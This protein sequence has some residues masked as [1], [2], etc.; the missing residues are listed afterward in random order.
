M[1]SAKMLVALFTL[2]EKRP[3]SG[4]ATCLSCAGPLHNGL[5]YR[6]FDWV[7]GAIRKCH[8]IGILDMWLISG[9]VMPMN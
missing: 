5:D 9:Q 1:L 8:L 2:P 3:Q 6:L 4:T 7:D